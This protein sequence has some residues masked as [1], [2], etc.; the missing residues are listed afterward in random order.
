[1]RAPWSPLALLSLVLLVLLGCSSSSDDDG[2]STP[3][4]VLRSTPDGV[5]Q[6]TP[7]LASGP[8][9]A[10][11]ASEGSTGKDLNGDGD[12]IDAVAIRVHTKSRTRTNVRVAAESIAWL[13][14]TLFVAVDEARDDT[15][16]SGDGFLDDLVLLYLPSADSSPTYLR[17]LDATHATPMAVVGSRLLLATSDTPTVAGETNLA[18]VTVSTTGAAPDPETP[19]T[20]SIVDAGGDGVSCSIW[21][22][23]GGIAFLTMD[24]GLDGEL[25]GDGDAD[26]AHVLAL[27]D[28][29]GA[30]V[31]S[32]GLAVDPAGPVD[33]L[34][35]AGD[36]TI[37]FLVDES[38]QGA[39]LNDPALFDPSWQPGNCFG[40]SDVDLDDQ[41]LHWCLYSGLIGSG[42]VVNT[43][44]VGGGDP[45]EFVYALKSGSRKYVGCVSQEADEGAGVGCDL[46]GDGDWDDRIFRWVEA[47]DP[48]APAL[49]VTDD[50]KLLAV[51]DAVP[52]YGGDSTGGVVA[53][54]Q[55][56]V[57]LVDEA[58]DGRDHDGDPG[59][60]SRLVA[61]HKPTNVGQGWNFAHG[62]SN[63]G[64]V[65]VSWMASSPRTRASF[66]A[67]LSEASLDSDLNGDGDLA[68]SVPTFPEV[69]SGSTL[70]FP[71]IG[72]AC[73]SDDAGIVSAN[74]I[75]FFRL[76]E[77]EDGQN[78]YNGDG[79]FG[80]PMLVRLYKNTGESPALMETL[81]SLSV[82][83]VALPS[84]GKVEFGALLFEESKVG[85]TGED[86]NGD[87]DG[88]DFV[89]R[90][91][92]F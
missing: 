88:N 86:L 73:D 92:R 23:E 89:V 20:T 17:D 4:F 7:L 12:E 11:L 15:D 67:A 22:V 79:D 32:T 53:L 3:T 85:A 37:A 54:D 65:S 60:D 59:T 2:S 36:Y 16:W 21:K 52:G 6:T 71:G 68:D 42:A 64:P 39:N 34:A 31:T 26:D 84:S 77:A 25:N 1:M 81:N 49:P 50:A 70:K 63:P 45:T 24:E 48:F 58:A 30:V 43:G 18:Y 14:R 19:V 87:G 41:V 10:Y 66:V 56:W 5:P 91:F 29:A 9:L 40:F 72:I 69:Q 35:D 46:N 76:S 38:D 61:A 82:P 55:V 75:G 51:A 8:L 33:V 44:L 13:D 47:T 78:D 90:Y 27:L 83:A 74:G 57:L 28:Q 80:D 62:T